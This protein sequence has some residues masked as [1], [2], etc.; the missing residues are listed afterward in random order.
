[1]GKLQDLADIEGLEVDE[2]LEQGVF[3]S[4]AYGICMNPDCDFTTQYE[5]DQDKGWCD[6]C[7][8]NTVK[9]CLILAGIM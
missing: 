1:M 4:L 9:S 2:M 7:E 6:L 8:T 5:P 3:D